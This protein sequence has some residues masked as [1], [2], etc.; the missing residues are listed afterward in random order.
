MGKRK[1]ILYLLLGLFFLLLSFVFNSKQFKNYLV[2]QDIHKIENKL[3]KQY[4]DFES[5]YKSVVEHKDSLSLNYFTQYNNEV[6]SLSYFQNNQLKYWSNRNNLPQS[7]LTNTASDSLILLPFGKTYYLVSNFSVTEN[8]QLIIANPIVNENGK[9]IQL[10]HAIANYHISNQGS[11]AVQLPSVSNKQLTIEASEDF[12]SPVLLILSWVLAIVFTV[13]GAYQYFVKKND[14]LPLLLHHSLFGIVLLCIAYIVTSDP[15]GIFKGIS[16]FQTSLY[17]NKYLADS[18]GDLLIIVALLGLYMQYWYKKPMLLQKYEHHLPKSLLYFFV[19]V[20]ITASTFLFFYAFRSLILDSSEEIYFFL[21]FNFNALF[22]LLAMLFIGWVYFFYIL[23]IIRFVAVRFQNDNILILIFYCLVVLLTFSLFYSIFRLTNAIIFLVW[24]QALIIPL[25]LFQINGKRIHAFTQVI[26][27]IF[28][29]ALIGA[30][31]L[32]NYT[33]EKDRYRLKQIARQISIENDYF[34]SFLLKRTNERIT[35]DAVISE[36][37][38]VPFFSRNTVQQRIKNLYLAPNFEDYVYNIEIIPYGSLP[39]SLINLKEP[40][41]VLKTGNYFRYEFED[42]IPIYNSSNRLRNVIKINLFKP[43]LTESEQYRPLIDNSRNEFSFLNYRKLSYS[44]LSNNELVDFKGSVVGQNSDLLNKLQLGQFKKL[45]TKNADSYAYRFNDNSYVI[46]SLPTPEI[47]NRY[48]VNLSYTFAIIVYIYVF[49]VLVFSKGKIANF[50]F[51][52]ESLA[53]R[54]KFF[55]LASTYI[56]AIVISFIT[57]RLMYT[58]IADNQ[59]EIEN[60]NLHQIGEEYLKNHSTLDNYTLGQ[61]FIHYLSTQLFNSENDYHYFD[62]NGYLAFTND[63]TLFEKEIWPNRVSPAALAFLREESNLIFN[64]KETVLGKQYQGFYYGLKDKDLELSGILYHPDFDSKLETSQRQNT[65]ANLLFSAFTIVLTLLTF[66]ILAL[67]KSFTSIL[68][69]IRKRISFVEIGENYTPLT[70]EYEDEIGLLVKEYNAM[71]KKLDEN[72]V[73]LARTERESAWRE[74]AKQVA[75]EIKNPLTPMLL[76]I[77]HLNRKVKN[78][79][80]EIQESLVST[81]KTL[82]SQVKHLSKIANDFSSVSKMS[83]PEFHKIDLKEILS[84]LNSIFATNS[85]YI[86]ESF[87]QTNTA[88]CF[89]NADKTMMNRVFTNLLKNSVQAIKGKEDALV[90]LFLSESND[91][92]IVEIIDNGVGIAPKNRAKIFTPNFTT[93]KA[94]TGIGLMMSKKIVETHKGEIFFESKLNE[95]T[96]FTVKL[97]KYKAQD[98]K[99]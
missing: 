88:T 4:Q 30:F 31:L 60:N 52:R 10:K 81:L 54:V 21:T 38:S 92:F 28:C 51:F 61:Q 91:F 34:A 13:L 20:F 99:E 97:P 74:I 18:L 15:F 70:W 86:Y 1:D 7:V 68:E 14:K 58:E 36:Q 82:E 47:A 2:K 76:S 95:G 65:F 12:K 75:H 32:Q 83:L 55:I 98:E 93:K 16:I 59:R 79:E 3:A 56:S 84:D 9:F 19:S 22:I 5:I 49:F 87:D 27:F 17:A 72:A 33:L 26:Y 77:Q 67:S 64:K 89:I 69:T 39:D 78:H 71:V 66:V 85:N 43:K 63:P 53:N 48:I 8:E 50:T 42:Y 90:Q 80:G 45:N 73:V 11:Y 6:Y 94:G 40:K 62:Q 29:F 24:M 23:K 25:F 46:L 44:V 41:L 57:F 96:T 37:L 35:K